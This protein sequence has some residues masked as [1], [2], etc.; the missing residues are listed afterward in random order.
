MYTFVQSVLM[1]YVAAA[2]LI[3][4]KRQKLKAGARGKFTRNK[5]Q[6]SYPP[7]YKSVKKKPMHVQ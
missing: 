5:K 1:C 7:S 2:E 3:S 4:N 6:L